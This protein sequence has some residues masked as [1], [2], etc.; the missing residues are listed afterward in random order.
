LII[1]EILLARPGLLLLLP[2]EAVHEPSATASRALGGLLPLLLVLLRGLL[3]LLRGLLVLLGRWLLLHL[4][5]RLL[6]VG[7]IPLRLHVLLTC[8]AP[9]GRRGQ[10]VG[11]GPP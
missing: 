1:L 4:L 2:S 11:A 8:R 3:V 10:G 5:V 9:G 6:L 7:A